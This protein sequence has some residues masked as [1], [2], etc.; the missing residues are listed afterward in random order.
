MKDL[1][2]LDGASRREFA[3]YAAKDYFVLRVNYRGTLGYGRKFRE[4]LHQRKVLVE[5]DTVHLGYMRPEP[6]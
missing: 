4:E 2:R 3:A 6:F 1:L 5:I